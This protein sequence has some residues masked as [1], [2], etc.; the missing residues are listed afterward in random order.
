MELFDTIRER[1]IDSVRDCFVGM[2]TPGSK[3]LQVKV[4]GERN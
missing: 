3:G 1:D 4:L 2:P